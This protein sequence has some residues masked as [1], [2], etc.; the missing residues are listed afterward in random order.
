MSFREQLAS[1]IAVLG[2]VVDAGI[3]LTSIVVAFV[4]GELDKD[5]AQGRGRA[6]SAV[7][8]SATHDPGTVVTS[9]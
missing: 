1:G 4:V 9:R 2:L 6:P 3:A 8:E 7:P 5:R